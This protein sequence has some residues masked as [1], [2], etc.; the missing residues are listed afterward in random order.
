IYKTSKRQKNPDQIHFDFHLSDVGQDIKQD[1]TA[2]RETIEIEHR[3]QQDFDQS[4][5]QVRR[6]ITSLTPDDRDPFV[7]KMDEL[8]ALIDERKVQIKDNK[9]SYCNRC[10]TDFL[11]TRIAD[12]QRQ[13]EAQMATDINATP[14]HPDTAPNDTTAPK[15]TLSQLYTD[16]DRRRFAAAKESLADMQGIEHWLPEI[17]LY[18]VEDTMVTIAVPTRAFHESFTHYFGS[19]LLDKL[20]ETFGRKVG[21]YFLERL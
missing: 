10:F 4:P 3:L 19:A 1:K 5:A 6:I 18:Q 16:D 14:Q 17:G 11:H 13:M 20:E 21:V 8:K 12:K 9:R 2:Q 7:R 15:G